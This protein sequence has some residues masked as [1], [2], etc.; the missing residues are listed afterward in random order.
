MLSFSKE[1]LELF[2]IVSCRASYYA[3]QASKICIKPTPCDMLHVP[4][5]ISREKGICARSGEWGIPLYTWP[6]AAYSIGLHHSWSWFQPWLFASCLK[7]SWIPTGDVMAHLVSARREW[8]K[9][10]VFRPE[11]IQSPCPY[12]WPHILDSIGQSLNYVAYDLYKSFFLVKLQGMI[13]QHK[14]Q[15]GADLGHWTV[16]HTKRSLRCQKWISLVCKEVTSALSCTQW[17]DN[18]T[19]TLL[20]AFMR[21]AILCPDTIGNVV[22]EASTGSGISG[23]YAE[24]LAMLA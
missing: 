12:V 16:D 7:I 24:E 2:W 1:D 5:R 8:L 4:S 18:I 19:C 20:N 15:A 14:S 10:N 21:S 23:I 13:S 3:C 9:I 17:P 11:I 22:R 6:A